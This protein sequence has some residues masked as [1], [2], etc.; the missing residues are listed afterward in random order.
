MDDLGLRSIKTINW[1]A[2]NFYKACQLSELYTW[3]W[4]IVKWHVSAD[5]I[6][7]ST[8]KLNTD[9]YALDT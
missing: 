1:L 6:R 4:D 7:M 8:I 5:T 3:A 2:D 9:L